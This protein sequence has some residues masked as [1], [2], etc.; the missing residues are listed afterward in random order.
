MGSSLAINWAY[1][2]L[3]SDT[4]VVGATML[5][6]DYFLTLGMEVDLV[7]S[8]HWSPMNVVF[9][10]QRYL[11]FVDAAALCFICM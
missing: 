11:P 8:S 7:W 1:L 5:L 4:T 9:I 2:M 10:A 3:D 6:Y